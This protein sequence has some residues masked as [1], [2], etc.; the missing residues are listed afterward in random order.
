MYILSYTEPGLFDVIL[1]NVANV[2][3][4]GVVDETSPFVTSLKQS[5]SVICINN[6]L[7]IVKD[8]CFSLYN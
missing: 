4:F 6:Y 1:V 5:G 2:V 8:M 3:N 7:T